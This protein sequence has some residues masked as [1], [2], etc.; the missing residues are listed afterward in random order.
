MER[1]N[2]CR[3]PNE[4]A[5]DVENGIWVDLRGAIATI[6]LTDVYQSMA[7]KLT[8]VRMKPV[9]SEIVQGR[10]LGTIESSKYVGK[11]VSPY[12]G[13][14]EAINE[15][16]SNNPSLVNKDPY[17]AGWIVK[18]KLDSHES[19]G[20]LSGQLAISAFKK[21]ISELKVTCFEIPPD[22]FL[23]TLGLLC[24]GPVS[25][26]SE[27]V[28]VMNRGEVIHMI[29]DDPAAELDVISWAKVTG[30]ELVELRKEEE[31]TILHF[32]VRKTN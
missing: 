16:L 25:R 14:I 13:R 30:Q 10:S 3:I 19:T 32:L 28:G 11:V 22:K 4:L 7:S 21:R 15:S 20:L 27:E 6:G 29:A 9:G 31:N 17:G 5:Y 23:N 18:L 26:L 2:G 1:I 12:N 8:S 24:P